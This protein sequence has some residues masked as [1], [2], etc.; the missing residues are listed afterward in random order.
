M[1]VL[2]GKVANTATTILLSLCFMFPWDSVITGFQY[3]N[4][5]YIQFYLWNVYQLYKIKFYFLGSGM[6][7]DPNYLILLIY[8]YHIKK[9]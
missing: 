8:Q 1:E 6:I 3:P 4:T 5:I 7:K 9:K 2:I